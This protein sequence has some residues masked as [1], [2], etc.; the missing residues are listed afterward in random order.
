MIT[1]LLQGL[2]SHTTQ[3]HRDKQEGMTINLP[4]SLTQTKGTASNI[5][6]TQTSGRYDL[7]SRICSDNAEG[8]NT[9]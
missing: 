2:T 6:V 1:V 5:P 7:I 9:V 4:L 8:A 3:S